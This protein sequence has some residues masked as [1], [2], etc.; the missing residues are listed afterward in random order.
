VLAAT[1]VDID[2]LSNPRRARMRLPYAARAAKVALSEATETHVTLPRRLFGIASIP[3]T[4]DQLNAVFSAQM[5]N[6]E[7]CIAD[8]LKAAR[9][10]EQ[11]PGSAYDISRT[12]IETLVQGVD[13]V[14]L[15]GGMCRIPYVAE[16]LKQMFPPS[17]VVELASGEPETAVVNGLAKAGQYGRI[18]MYRP[19]FDVLLEWDGDFRTVYEAFTPLVERWQIARGGSDLRYVQNGLDLYLPRAGHGRLRVVSQSG[20]RIRA[21]LGGNSLDGFP[22]ALSEQK[23]E[24]SIYPSGRIR[25]TDGSGTYEGHVG[26][27]HTM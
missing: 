10:T 27:W 9:L 23:F 8:T 4:R 12:P 14:V 16:R 6:A 21:T 26:T 1:G 22:V 13:V 7:L 17:T 19:S 25:M 11:A 5:D 3:Y 24:F 2:A 18:N 20:D 15:S